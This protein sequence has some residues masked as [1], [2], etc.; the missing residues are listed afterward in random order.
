MGCSSQCR[1]S[2]DVNHA[3]SSHRIRRC[4]CSRLCHTG[5]GARCVVRGKWQGSATSKSPLKPCTTHCH[6]I[7][8]HP[9]VP[10]AAVRRNHVNVPHRKRTLCVNRHACSLPLSARCLLSRLQLQ[11]LLKC[12]GE[13]ARGLPRTTEG[14]A[15]GTHGF[16]LQGKSH[17]DATTTA[18]EGA[19][20]TFC[21]FLHA[22][23]DLAVRV[24]LNHLTA[25]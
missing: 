15:A 6:Q 11:R 20:L 22:C 21:L 12:A 18:Q 23:L 7:H 24:V 4:L 14:A 25:S 5:Q 13:A 19:S 1:S 10:Q 9:I 16:H 17:P 8:T 3:A 2:V